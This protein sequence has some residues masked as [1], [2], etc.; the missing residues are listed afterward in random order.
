[1]TITQKIRAKNTSNEY[2]F[3]SSKRKHKGW[4]EC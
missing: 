2:A 3:N 1:M 4:E